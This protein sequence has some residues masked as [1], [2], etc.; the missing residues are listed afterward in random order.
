MAEQAE[1]TGPKYR[2]IADDLLAG[3][4]NGEYPVGSRIPTKSELMTRY[5]VAVNTVERA[6][7]ELRDAGLIQTAQGAGMFVLGAAESRPGAPDERLQALESEVSRLKEDFAVL[8]AQIR[9]LHHGSE[10]P[11]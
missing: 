4:R 10:P 11:H 5:G 1:A 8:Q 2:Q 9:D 7:K 6:I 3:I